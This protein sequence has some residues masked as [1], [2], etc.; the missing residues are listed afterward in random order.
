MEHT[1]KTRSLCEDEIIQTALVVESLFEGEDHHAYHKSPELSL[2]YKTFCKLVIKAYEVNV[3]K[4]YPEPLRS[5]HN[6][7]PSFWAD[8]YVMIKTEGKVNSL[9]A[10]VNEVDNLKASIKWSNFTSY[11]GYKAN[12]LAIAELNKYQALLLELNCLPKF[13]PLIE[14]YSQTMMVKETF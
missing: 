2:L 9:F 13:K 10:L 5:L 7:T 12:V 4:G 14:A 3:R 8:T 1:P 11:Q 6:R